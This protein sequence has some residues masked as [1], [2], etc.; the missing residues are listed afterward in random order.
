MQIWLSDVFFPK[1]P[2]NTLLLLDSSSGFKDNELILSVKPDD[3]KLL[4]KTI[5]PKTTPIAQPLDR[6][7]FRPY[8][9][10]VRKISDRILLDNLN[11]NLFHRDSI[12]II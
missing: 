6:Y 4:I 9:N 10:F 3:V 8:K 1:A 2:K 11:I 7:F 5:P 12:L